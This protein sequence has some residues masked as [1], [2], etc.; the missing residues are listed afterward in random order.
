MLGHNNEYACRFAE[1][2]EKLKNLG[3]KGEVALTG[4][5]IMISTAKDC[6]S[7]WRKAIK[8]ACI[9]TGCERIETRPAKGFY[10]F[11]III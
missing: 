11:T 8:T 2:M 1:C 3:L 9:K 4:N 7:L 6:A 5:V 10:V